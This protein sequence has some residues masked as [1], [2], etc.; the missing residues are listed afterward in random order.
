MTVICE[1]LSF[2]KLR[3]PAWCLQNYLEFEKVF[4]KLGIALL[5][6]CL[7]S[8][9]EQ[10]KDKKNETK[11]LWGH[12]PLEINASLSSIRGHC[13]IVSLKLKVSTMHPIINA[14]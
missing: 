11:K 10:E 6:A 1:E 9:T 3:L 5:H 7:D 14:R 2:K 13:L 12:I 8:F 4:K